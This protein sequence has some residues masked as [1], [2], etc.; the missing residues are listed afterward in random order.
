MQS[1]FFTTQSH[2][3]FLGNILSYRVQVIASLYVNCISE[4]RSIEYFILQCRDS[5]QFDHQ[6][7]ACPNKKLFS[8]IHDQ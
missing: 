2:G 8:D 6:E 5:V 7:K 4:F 1:L 3:I